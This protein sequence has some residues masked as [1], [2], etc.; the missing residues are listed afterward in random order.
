M[1]DISI[2]AVPR[3]P[4]AFRIGVTGSRH[5]SP[6]EMEGLRP[7]VADILALIARELTGLAGDPRAKAVYGPGD[8]APRLVSPLAMGADRLVAEEGL[9]AGYAL[10]APL[11]FQQAE[12]EKDFPEFRRCFPRPAGARRDPG[13]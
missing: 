9:R 6:E 3:P 5:L 7:A 12:Y 4:L 1:P 8:P 11:P 10:Y 13:A 2:P